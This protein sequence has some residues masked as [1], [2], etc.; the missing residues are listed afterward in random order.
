MP[1]CSL[2]HIF[3]FLCIRCITGYPTSVLKVLPLWK[4]TRQHRH[5]LGFCVFVSREETLS[6]SVNA[7][8]M[9]IKQMPS[10]LALPYHHLWLF[11]VCLRR[12]VFNSKLMN[13]AYHSL[14]TI[15]LPFSIP[16]NK[17]RNM[18]QK[19][20]RAKLS[21]LKICFNLTAHHFIMAYATVWFV[22]AM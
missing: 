7:I 16:V 3:R 20:K 9:I 19:H 17:K 14:N 2:R 18:R 15:S 10:L 5:R 13:L 12:F 8:V 22:Y 4:Q 6:S 11:S 1:A 21:E